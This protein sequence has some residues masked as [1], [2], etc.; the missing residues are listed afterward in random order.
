MSKR[1]HDLV[2][3]TGEYTDSSG[4]VKPR[5]LNVGSILERDDG[6][7]F[8]LL[9]R[10]FSPAGIPNPENRDTVII[11]M[12]RVDDK[13]KPDRASTPSQSFE[14]DIPF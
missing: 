4:A 12:F 11:S 14:D 2:V 10:T 6:G 1:S 13:N 5:W 7:R 9:N 8:M 3:K